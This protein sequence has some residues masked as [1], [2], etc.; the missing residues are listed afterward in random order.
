MVV[1]TR[2]S[3]RLIVGSAGSIHSFDT[4]QSVRDHYGDSVFVVAIDTNCR[5]LVAASVLADAF[6]RVP[7]AR[8]PEFPEALRAIAASYPGAHYLPY[9]DEEIEVAARLA[10]EGT[11]PPGL[12][13]ISPPY[14]I[15]RICSDKWAMHRWL[16]ANGLSSP[17]T[18]LATPAGIQAIRPPII[19]KPREGTGG[20]GVRLVHD[21]AELA[22]LD[23]SRWLL[24]EQ[25]QMPEVGV[26]AFLSRSGA[27]FCC[28][29]REYIETR[30]GEPVKSRVFDDP[31][32]RNIAERVARGLPIFG[33]FFF[34]IMPDAASRWR[35]I[36]VHPRLGSATGMS[37]A[38][39]LDFAA[40]NLADFWGEPTTAALTPL[41]GEHYVI[42]QYANYVTSRNQ[43]S[44]G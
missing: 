9:H 8:A 29:C 34:Q 5:E 19:L 20:R 26:D 30:A 2:K 6:V 18:T 38:L 14:D 13:L 23:P 32:I 17:K 4:I 40:A 24:Q 3:R 36:D 39:G 44:R 12:E 42:R 33:A 1:M 7:P 11:L 21:K 31:V 41:A 22:G 16:G 25:L 37:A 35:I 15:V 10:A 27:T 28:V 43:H